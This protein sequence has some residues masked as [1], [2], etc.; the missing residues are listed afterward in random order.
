ML[1]FLNCF[2]NNQRSNSNHNGPV[3]EVTKSTYNYGSKWCKSGVRG[4]A[5]GLALLLIL[6]EVD[7]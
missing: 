6:S 5:R 1:L 2:V 7:V 3:G 4:L